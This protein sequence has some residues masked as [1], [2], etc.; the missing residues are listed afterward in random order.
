MN[1]KLYQEIG[2]LN[3]GTP[4]RKTFQSKLTISLLGKM[5]SISTCL[6]F[7]EFRNLDS[8]IYRVKGVWPK[9]TEIWFINLKH[10]SKCTVTLI[11]FYPVVIK[12]IFEIFHINLPVIFYS[13]TK[14]FVSLK[15]G[16]LL[17]ITHFALLRVRIFNEKIFDNANKI[18]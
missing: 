3:F 2:K 17:Y 8:G 16:T 7:R 4:Q 10:C 12:C 14:A 11:Q 18:S 13:S 6:L 9:T 1:S 5:I 15:V